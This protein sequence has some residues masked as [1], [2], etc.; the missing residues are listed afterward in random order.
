MYLK[1]GVFLFSMEHAMKKLIFLAIYFALFANLAKASDQFDCNK[2]S[3]I[4]L[5]SI[6]IENADELLKLIPSDEILKKQFPNEFANLK[7]G[8]SPSKMM[9]EKLQS[10][11][12]NIIESKKKYDINI[13]EF[14]NIACKLE[15]PHG[16]ANPLKALT[17][18]YDYDGHAGEITFALLL[19]DEEYYIL[20]ILISYDIFNFNK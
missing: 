4:L 14:E 1:L 12:D 19:I 7:Q 9:K 18:R 13:S 16:D 2:F 5:K 15:S 10:D 6:E 17:I 3:Q 11:F 8:E 20:S